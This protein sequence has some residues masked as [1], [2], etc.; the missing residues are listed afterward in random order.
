MLFAQKS[1]VHRKAGF[2]WW[3]TH[4][5]NI[6]KLRLRDW[7]GPEGQFSENAYGRHWISWRVRIVAR[8][9]NP[10]TPPKQ[11]IPLSCVKNVE[12]IYP[13]PTHLSPP[14]KKKGR[15]FLSGC[16]PLTP[17][18]VH[19]RTEPKSQK[20][21]LNS[22]QIGVLR[23]LSSSKQKSPALSVPVATGGDKTQY[24]HRHCDL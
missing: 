12:F 10:T 24:I 14:P 2:S 6:Q 9:A 15:S 11:I 23:A 19:C 7:S 20:Y 22:P 18:T 3:N 17:L 4:T 21:V 13:N 16:L 1:S 5:H 8:I